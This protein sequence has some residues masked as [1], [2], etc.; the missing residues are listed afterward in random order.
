MLE[1][2]TIRV[3]ITRHCDRLSQM[4]SGN[5][6]AGYSRRTIFIGR[7]QPGVHHAN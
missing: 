6:K 3:Y 2:H 7:F 5:K 1:A 4:L